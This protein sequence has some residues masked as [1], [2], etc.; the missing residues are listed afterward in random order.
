VDGVP[1]RAT[2]R[3]RVGNA[4]DTALDT[5]IF[6]LNPGLQVTSVQAEDGGEL[7]WYRGAS[8]LRVAPRASLAPEAKTTVTVAY[9]GEIDRDGFDLLREQGGA[10]LQKER[11]KGDLTAWIRET[12]AFLPPRCRWYPTAGVD[13]GHNGDRG[14][15][16]ATARITVSVPAGLEA[17]SQGR[18]VERDTL[19]SRARSVWEVD[20]PVPVLSLNAGV[21]EVYQAQIHGIDCAFYVHPAHR[22]QILFFEDARESSLEALDQILDAME[23]ETGLAYPYPRLSVVEVPFHVQWYYEGWEEIGGLT[24]PGV[25]MVEEDVL[26]RL[27]FNRSLKMRKRWSRGRDDP[28]KLKRDLL[29]GAIFRTF[30]GREEARS[31]LFRSP[32]VQLWSFDKAFG[33]ENSALL[34]RGMPLHMQS[35]LGANLQEMF[36]T[37]RGR[38]FGRFRR[39][40]RQSSDTPWDTLLVKMQQRSLADLDPEEDPELYRSVLAAKGASLFNMMQTVLGDDVFREIL[41]DFGEAHRYSKATFESFEKAAVEDSSRTETGPNL[42][43]LVRDW[44]YG[45]HV[46]GYTLT[47]VRAYKVDD[48]FGM[49]VYQV[50][51]RIR[52]GEPGRGFVQVR[53]MGREDEAVK[54]V[55]IEGGQEVEVALIVWDRPFRVMVEPF[56]ARNRAPLM[57]PLRIPDET[58]ETMPESYVR[59][60]TEE[61]APFSEIVVDN[62]DEG[63]S[64]PIRRVQRFLRPGLK[65]DNWEEREMPMAYGRYEANFRLKRGG[66]GAQPAVWRT[67]LPHAGEYDVAYYFLPPRIWRRMGGAGSFTL[68][69]SHGSGT[70]TLTLRS[71]DLQG[72]WNL[73]G[74]YRFEAGEEVGVELSDR[75]A[76]S[77]YADAVRWRYVDPDRPEGVFDEG[78]PDWGQGFGGR[79]RGPGGRGAGRRPGRPGQGW[80]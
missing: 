67:R 17:V 59:E 7:D 18:P 72:G 42:R 20:R 60:I 9:E 73:L 6:T 35:D 71:D 3:I 2:A 46:P 76:G 56:F 65:G 16:F 19:G 49:V 27:R 5:L 80:F 57:A 44:I 62:D 41:D 74:R 64:M 34:E 69:V 14:A 63:F 30:I 1:L 78:I 12:S 61:E 23:Q 50:I 51:V 55:E 70:D 32:V 28:E 58:R 68:K 43:G 4:G 21:Y 48:G 13:Y 29:V 77:L 75:A 33:G 15:S 45:T 47:R 8:V 53:A 38:M 25:L 31:G 26:M 39:P 24:Q 11:T 22:R 79:G 40:K 52:N 36:Y 66:D 37:R 10:R 54:G